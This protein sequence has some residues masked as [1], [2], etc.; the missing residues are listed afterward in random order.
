MRKPVLSNSL[1]CEGIEVEPGR[2]VFLADGPEK[3]AGAAAHLLDKMPLRRSLAEAGF[4]AV[5]ERYNWDVIARDLRPVY[6][7]VL[8]DRGKVQW[9]GRSEASSHKIAGMAD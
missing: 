3:F 8:E 6:K 4:Q 5:L 9:R 2:D 7:S 1:G